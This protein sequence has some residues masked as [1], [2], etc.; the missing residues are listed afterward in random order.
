[1]SPALLLMAKGC[2]GWGWSQLHR[3]HWVMPG[4]EVVVIIHADICMIARSG[5]CV[6]IDTEC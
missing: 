6:A 4:L 3:R 1:M 2:E 5:D